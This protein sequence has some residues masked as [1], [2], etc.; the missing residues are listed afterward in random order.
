MIQASPLGASIEQFQHLYSRIHRELHEVIVGLDHV[1]EGSLAGLF[2]GGHVLLEGVPGIGKTLLIKSIS[3]VLGLHCKRI[4]FTPDLMPSDITGTEVISEDES[5]R[6]AFQFK[7]GPV[8]SN[9]ILADEINR[10][11]PKTQAALLEAMAEAQVTVL[12]KTYRLPQPFFVL[13]TQNPIE[14]EGTYPLPEAQLDR[15]LLKLEV[16]APTAKDL[17]EVLLRTTGDVHKEVKSVFSSQAPETIQAMRALVRQ[18]VAPEPL[19]DILVR[20]MDLLLP[21]SENATELTKKYVRFGPGPRGAQSIL[22]VAKFYALRE[23]RIHISVDDI[24]R[25]S[26]PA[27]RHRLVVNFQADADG[28]TTDTVIADA[29]RK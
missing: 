29:L 25:A 6:R 21:S 4:Q 22:L 18:V 19:L 1:I 23:G 14:L 20:I 2:C 12:D 5:G 26:I 11:T 16:P 27:L 15:F 10:A 8:F 17:K 13:A 9:V 3:N 24:R 28:I 7:A